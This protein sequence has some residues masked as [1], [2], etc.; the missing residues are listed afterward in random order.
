MAEVWG[1]MSV[2]LQQGSACRGRITTDAGL[3]AAHWQK[4]WR[5][6]KL[7]GALSAEKLLLYAPLLRRY[8]E[9]GQYFQSCLSHN[10]LSSDQD[11]HLVC[12]GGDGGSAARR[13]GQEQGAAC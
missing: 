7:V 2:L 13:R 10:R 11:L 9:H 1:D 5:R 4:A 8:V 12:E 3:L 6:K